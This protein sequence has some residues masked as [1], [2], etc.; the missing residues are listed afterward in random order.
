MD[1]QQTPEKPAAEEMTMQQIARMAFRKFLKDR[2][3]LDPGACGLCAGV[4]PARVAQTCEA[5]WA[6]GLCSMCSKHVPCE[7]HE[8]IAMSTETRRAGFM[9]IAKTHD[10]AIACGRCGQ[11]VTISVDGIC[12]SCFI[13]DGSMPQTGKPAPKCAL[14]GLA[15]RAVML[16]GPTGGAVCSV[17]IESA[18]LSLSEH[19]KLAGEPVPTKGDSH[20]LAAAVDL[21]IELLQRAKVEA[22]GDVSVERADAIMTLV[23]AAD[24]ALRLPPIPK[25]IVDEVSSRR[26]KKETA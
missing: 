9:K 20:V 14:C 7:F 4:V 22:T 8:N 11:P 2:N 19:K 12:G 18:T 5:C 15:D 17:C 21:A 13:G 6:R 26:G 10:Q 3:G 24:H 16:K 23:D 1:Q 25:H